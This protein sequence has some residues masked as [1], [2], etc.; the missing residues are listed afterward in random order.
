[1]VSR[2]AHLGAMIGGFVGAV[3]AVA[4]MSAFGVLNVGGFAGFL[5][6]FGLAV[7]WVVRRRRGSI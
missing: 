6:P 5:V 4:I 1:M 3:V 7:A 2:E